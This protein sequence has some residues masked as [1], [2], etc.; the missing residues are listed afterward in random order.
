VELHERFADWL[1]RRAGAG[2]HEVEDIL[3][4]HRDQ[5]DRFRV[6]IGFADHDR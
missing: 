4:Y 5:A 3:T 6:E 1:E 2:V